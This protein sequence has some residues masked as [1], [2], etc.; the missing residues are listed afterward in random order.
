[1][2]C[3]LSLKFIA[4]THDH[5]PLNVVKCQVSK[6]SADIVRKGS[7]TGARHVEGKHAFVNEAHVLT[8]HFRVAR[9]QIAR[10]CS[11]ILGAS[12]DYVRRPHK[13]RGWD[14]SM[15]LH[16]IRYFLSLSNTLNF[17]RAAEEC[18]VSQP[19][20]SRAISQLEAEL[21][22]ELFRRERKLTHLTELGRAVL[23]P[24]RQC[25]EANQSAKTLARDF[26]KKGQAPLNIALARSIEM[27]FLSPLLAE[28]GAAFPS[29]EINL[30]RGASA[31]IVERLRHGDAEIAIA[32]PLSEEWERLE[33]RKL[34]EQKFGLL[35]NR[36]HRLSKQDEVE[37]LDLVEE[38]LLGRPNCTLTEALLAKLREMGA[39]HITK[40]EVSL[41]DD[42]PGLVQANFGVGI[43]PVTRKFDGDL[44]VNNVHG[45][46][47]SRWVQVYTVF[48]RKL[49][50]AAMTLTT[51]LRSRDWSD[52]APPVQH[53][54]ELVH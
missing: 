25:F 32:G 10:Y 9:E 52:M 22:G 39:T 36:K 8:A 41:I 43:W 50:V 30:F 13:V 6:A 51:L 46:A 34:Y 45:L 14:A 53:M 47:L 54:R 26:H 23:P 15:E 38:R 27:D 40:H 7:R 33:S 21:G 28:L 4:N 1:L 12:T 24:L 29:I 31:E 44:L 17:T 2:K 42:I 3:R 19:A 48:G 18:N 5:P 49:S 11:Q 16:Q 35:L 37:L 20:L